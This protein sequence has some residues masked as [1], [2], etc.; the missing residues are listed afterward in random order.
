MDG[1]GQ[2]VTRRWPRRL[3]RAGGCAAIALLCTAHVGSPDTF[4]EGRAGPYPVRVI[5]RAP[6]VIPARAEVIVRVSGGG[7]RRVT[8]APYIWNG[9]ERG[10][11]PADDLVRVAGDS[12]LWSVQL[13]IMAQGSY[14]VRVRVEGEGGTG[15]A[16]VPFTAVATA[17]LGMDRMMA[18]GLAGLGAFLAVGLLTIVGAAVREATLEPGLEPDGARVRRSWQVRGAAAV[19]VALLLLGGRAWWNA[20]YRAYAEGVFQNVRGTVTLREESGNRILRLA[21]DSNVVRWRRWTPFIPDHGKLMHLFLVKD[22]DL[23]AMMHLHPVALDSLTFETRVPRVPRGRYRVYGD[24]VHESGFAETIVSTV[25]LPDTDSRSAPTDADDAAFVGAAS[26]DRVATPDGT[27]LTWE[28]GA[29]PLVAGGDA[30]LR[31]V[32]RDRQGAIAAV[33]PYLGMAAHAVVVREDQSV[34]VHLH[35][36]GTAPLAAQ[37]ALAAFTPA[38]TARGAIR[39]KLAQG[40]QSMT[41]GE[42]MAGELMFP[43]AFPRAGRY[44]IWVQFRRGGAVRTAAFDAVVGEGGSPGTRL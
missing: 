16:L 8:A 33:E 18:A 35:P 30:R 37:R 36:G 19:V 31:F 11:P 42:R 14:S 41:M 22:G 38:D 34:F 27:T 10:A 25:D 3:A 29:A 6:Q 43:Y 4:F 21:I 1:A 44:R 2:A 20:E 17:V 12:T 7:I 39:A 13:W 40:D 5:I 23:A 24:V 26:G 15:T 9:G 32:L 28:R